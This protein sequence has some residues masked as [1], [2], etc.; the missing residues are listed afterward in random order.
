MRLRVYLLAIILTVVLPGLVSAQTLC[1]QVY[2][3]P[4][5]EPAPLPFMAV[6][7]LS[8]QQW[9]DQFTRRYQASLQFNYRTNTKKPEFNV[10]SSGKRAAGVPI[11]G[12]E[13]YPIELVLKNL[14][15]TEKLSS[16]S[17]QTRIV[18]VGEG[19]S[20]LVP[21]LAAQGF[22]VKGTDIWYDV[23]GLKQAL[24]AETAPDL[25]SDFEY[26]QK[27]SELLQAADATR[28][29]IES[30]T[31]DLVL[32][33]QL[34]NNLGDSK[35]DLA[36]Q[37]MIRVLSKGGEARIVYLDPTG[38]QQDYIIERLLQVPW[39]SLDIRRVQTTP[40]WTNGKPIM[41]TLLVIQ[42]TMDAPDL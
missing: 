29:P 39:L 21:M 14:G 28:L 41:S 20:Q 34:I 26:L 17:K 25:K 23:E 6:M 32:S 4:N 30:G 1:R 27:N 22:R 12:D 7:G 33:H 2:G 36:I 18:S 31:V 11:T 13:H 42:K 40:P 38:R 3:T 24:S 19:R 5:I 10:D 35:S 16:I 37:E 8:D 9:A 15:L